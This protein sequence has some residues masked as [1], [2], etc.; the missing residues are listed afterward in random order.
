[1]AKRKQAKIDFD[2]ANLPATRRQLFGDVYKTRLSLIFDLGLVLLG[3]FLPVVAVS[4]LTQLHSADIGYALAEDILS[5]EAAAAELMELRNAV[6]LL[7]IPCLLLLSLG[8]AGVCQIVKNLAWQ[9]G[10]LFRA[11]FAKG[12]RENWRSFCMTALIAGILNYCCGYLFNIGFLRTGTGRDLGLAA[13]MAAGGIFALALPFVLIQSTLYNLSYGKK[14]V[15]G[16]L[17][18]MRTFFPTLGLLALNLLPF[19]LLLIENSLVRICALLLLPL[20]VLPCLVI[21]DTLYVHS[22]L[23]TYINKDHFPEIYRKGLYS[24]ADH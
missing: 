21:L 11:D 20:A 2:V 23:D 12:V 1:M 15:N 5:A 17:L 9:E 6:N 19:G 10:I 16:I 4:M 22:V 7:L 18:S 13:V 24:H 8:L 14:L 3:F